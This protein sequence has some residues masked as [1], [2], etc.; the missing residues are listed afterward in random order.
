MD[1]K[2]L[3][4]RI[5]KENPSSEV[6]ERI[7]ES[8]REYVHDGWEDEFEDLDQAYDEQGRGEAENDILRSLITENCMH[9]PV[10]EDRQLYYMLVGHY[11]LNVD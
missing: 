3:F 8:K 9:L 1:I 10:E 6:L 5:A 11:E 2:P 4:I 7:Q